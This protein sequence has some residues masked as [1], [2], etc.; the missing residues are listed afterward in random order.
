MLKPDDFDRL[1]AELERDVLLDAPA[2]PA[3]DR[4]ARVAVLFAEAAEALS[5]LQPANRE[6]VD[7]AT[8]EAEATAGGLEDRAG[9][10][11]AAANALTKGIGRGGHGRPTSIADQLDDDSGP[12]H[13][14]PD[15]RTAMASSAKSGR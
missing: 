12:T 13:A 6:L 1:A 3:R 5:D 9:S 7:L 15:R 10:A 8:E 4:L 2:A 14:L 11:A